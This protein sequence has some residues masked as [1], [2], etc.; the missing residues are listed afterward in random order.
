MILQCTDLRI[1][2]TSLQPGTLTLQ[3]IQLGLCVTQSDLADIAASVGG[4]E[5]CPELGGLPV[6]SAQTEAGLITRKQ[7]LD[8]ARALVLRLGAA[9][10]R[11]HAPLR[12]LGLLV[13][14][15]RGIAAR[16]CATNAT[17]EASL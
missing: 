2:Y 14:V 17:E 13:L 5:T 11:R 16:G 12:Q 15:A 3:G 1:G 9:L 6:D 4:V 10:R 7:R 8:G